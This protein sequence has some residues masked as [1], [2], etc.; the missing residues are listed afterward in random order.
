M[1]TGKGQ[2]SAVEPLN[3][4]P[5]PVTHFIKVWRPL[6]VIKAASG[7]MTERSGGRQRD[8][9]KCHWWLEA[10]GPSALPPPEFTAME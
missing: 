10:Q 3:M 9:G 8:G 4:C 7:T 1:E 6:P 5:V 2:D